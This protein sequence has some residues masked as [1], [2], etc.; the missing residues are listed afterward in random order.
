MA[1]LAL[2]SF[3]FA[4]VL[5][6][7]VTLPAPP[8]PVSYATFNNPSGVAVEAG[9]CAC[10]DDIV[11]VADYQSVRMIQGTTVTT[12]AGPTDA[13]SGGQ[14]PAGYLNA[15][16]T[17][18]RFAYISAI[19]RDPTT[20]NLYVTE[21]TNNTVRQITPAGVVTTVAGQG[22]VTGP[23]QTPSVDGIGSAATFN[24]PTGI[25]I[26]PTGT[27]LYVAD[28]YD[29][30]IRRITI[31]TQLVET[32]IGGQYLF[33]LVPSAVRLSNPTGIWYQPGL[34]DQL[35][36]IDQG[37]GRI[38]TFNPA[39]YVP[40]TPLS[41]AAMAIMPSMITFSLNHPAGIAIDPANRI[42]LTTGN[43]G[44]MTNGLYGGPIGGSYPIVAGGT[45]A[46]DTGPVS[47]GTNARFNTPAGVALSPH[48]VLY[49]A[50]QRNNRIKRMGL[51]PSYPV[52]VRAGHEPGNPLGCRDGA[53]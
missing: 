18:A 46:G 11:Y 21:H 9:I 40:G 2:T 50:D 48:S 37:Y 24:H 43:G 10:D 1:R 34:P 12:L 6:G 45:V 30:S 27:Y 38:R 14:C 29:Y 5:S 28:S 22:P 33:Q 25:T 32:V 53:A 13:S 36:V 51:S 52:D 8:P 44:T 35:Y 39:I 41:P 23:V 3:A 16:G 4:V 17:A 47:I 42:Y 49:I 26:D 15:T 31:A 19:V 7:C 20:G